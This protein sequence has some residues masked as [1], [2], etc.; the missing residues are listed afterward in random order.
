MMKRQRSSVV[1]RAPQRQQ[2]KQWKDKVVESSSSPSPVSQRTAAELIELL[3]P[4]P[5]ERILDLECGTGQLA[6]R[7]TSLGAHVVGIDRSPDRIRQAEATFP[8]MWFEVADVMTFELT[9]PFDAVFSSENRCWIGQPIATVGR[10]WDFLRPGGRFVAEMGG[11]GNIRKV[12][13]AA[14]K[15]LL[16]L[17][18]LVLTS[19]A[20]LF[21]PSVPEWATLLQNQGF[22]TS[23]LQLF[24]RPV[25]L[26][27][28]QGVRQWIL[29][30]APRLLDGLD[31]AEREDLFTRV[32]QMLRPKHFY[33]GAWTIE[34]RW[35][36][37]VAIK[38]DDYGGG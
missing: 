14:R 2:E 15:A 7:I 22:E 37:F 10:I 28:E 17:D 26:E 18:R 6:A 1:R 27:G 13:A 30:E 4:A 9:N 36:R 29:N 32:E 8:G 35:L 3:A 33:E 19:A 11:I 34:S 31:A 24:D 16:G 38:P 12:I 20:P 23:F 21:S 5:D 25:R